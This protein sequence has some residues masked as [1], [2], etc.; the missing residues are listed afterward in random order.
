VSTL[1]FAD[2]DIGS[3]TYFDATV[4][5]TKYLKDSDNKIEGFLTVNNLG[6]KQPPII[7]G[8]GQPGQQ[9]PTNIFIYDVIGRYF[10][11]GVRF[12]F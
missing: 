11:A 12:K 7:P 6:D 4:S 9:Y 5:Y 10:T 3:L 2:N 1:F 8:G